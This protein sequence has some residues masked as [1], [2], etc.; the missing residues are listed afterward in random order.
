MNS[1]NNNETH[2]KQLFISEVIKSQIKF[3]I[4]KGTIF[5][6][7]NISVR[8]HFAKFCLIGI[9]FFTIDLR[10]FAWISKRF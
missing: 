1:F 9:V 5:K 3:N 6:K 7:F 8:L 4:Y 10:M 2:V